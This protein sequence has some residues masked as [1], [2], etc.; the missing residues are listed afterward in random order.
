MLSTVGNKQISFHL[1]NIGV[2]GRR[3]A[4]NSRC[5]TQF[6]APYIVRQ[7]L[8]QNLEHSDLPGL[9]GRQVPG[10]ILFLY[11][12][13]LGYQHVPLCLAF[14]WAQGIQTQSSCFCGKTLTQWTICLTLLSFKS[15]IWL[16]LAH[17]PV[18]P[19]RCPGLSCGDGASMV[20][21][22]P[23]EVF[24]IA[25]EVSFQLQCYAVL[26]PISALQ[27]P[28]L[29]PLTQNIPEKSIFYIIWQY[30]VCFIPSGCSSS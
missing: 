30:W 24:C 9:S 7:S 5:A 3:T 20:S 6:S 22:S 25:V 15:L 8:P 16:L 23:R 12:Q 11:Y 28:W 21:A 2:G 27:C 13:D 26:L 19:W 1:F 10:I 18:M 29:F 17:K 4:V 14:I